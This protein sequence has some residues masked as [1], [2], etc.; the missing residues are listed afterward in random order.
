MCEGFYLGLKRSHFSTSQKSFYFM[1]RVDMLLIKFEPVVC[2]GFESCIE[3]NPKKKSL[4]VHV[5]YRPLHKITKNHCIFGTVCWWWS[6]YYYFF[7]R[8][9]WLLPQAWRVRLSQHCTRCW[10]Q[11]RPRFRWHGKSIWNSSP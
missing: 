10:H 1:V 3:K 7:I 5:F 9:S 2:H 8:K 4:V 11:L 6:S